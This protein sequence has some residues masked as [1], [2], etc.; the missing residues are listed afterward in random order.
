MKVKIKESL[1]DKDFE[2]MEV[3]KV[4]LIITDSGDNIILIIKL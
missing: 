4:A 1:E 2:D 3:F